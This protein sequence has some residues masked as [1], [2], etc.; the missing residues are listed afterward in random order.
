MNEAK[1]SR[2]QIG[3]L[4]SH[5]CGFMIVSTFFGEHFKLLGLPIYCYL[6]ILC[7]FLLL[8][9]NHYKIRKPRI[10]QFSRVETF[11]SL[12]ILFSIV[13][14]PFSLGIAGSQPFFKTVVTA[15]IMLVV[16]KNIYDNQSF[17]Q[18]LKY[19]LIGII[20]TIAVC[21]YELITGRH[22]FAK[23][24]TDERLFRMGRDNSFGFQINVNDN[25]SL[26]ALSIFPVLLL[27]Q[28]KKFI[29]RL[30]S[31]GL[32]IALLAI[33]ISIDARL[34][35]YALIIVAIEALTLFFIFRHAKGT[36]PKF[37]VGFVFLIACIIFFASFSA[38][39]FLGLISNSQSY[40]N[41]YTRLLYMQWSLKSITPFS[42]LF[43]H[44]CG[45]T[46]SL[47]GG[48]SIHAV[49]VELLCDNGIFV[50]IC[51]LLIILK[52]QLAF[53]D[54]VGRFDGVFFSCFATAFFMISF[55]SSSMLR[56]RAVWVFLVLIYKLYSLK[57]AFSQTVDE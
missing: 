45:V 25:A 44:G 2:S 15:L 19:V 8:A 33:A 1:E 7:A 35:L 9:D 6:L 57:T 28:H 54:K 48:S 39:G 24:L 20:I 21:G 29:T 46:Q 40:L 27:F 43:G 12:L 34:P 10:I 49:I 22:F 32:L 3:T 31:V 23:V 47:I 38:S 37:V 4:E 11:S 14:L 16:A 13:M 26:V 52:L 18:V 50:A 56:V 51:L 42:I 5:I 55:C 30:F 36:V 17:E 53:A 41:D